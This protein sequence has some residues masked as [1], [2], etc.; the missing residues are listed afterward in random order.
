MTGQLNWISLHTMPE[1][2]YSVSDLSKSFK[3]G[4]TQDMRKLIKIV[5]RVKS[6]KGKVIIDE[7][8]EEGIYWEAYA[9]A[10]FGN[11]E[12]G[13]TQIGYIISLTDGKRRCPIWWKSRKARRVAKST[14]EA[15]ALSVGEAIEGLV[16]FNKLWEEIVG[17]GKLKAI[18]KTDSKTLMT[19]IKSSTGVSS[20]RLKID[21]AAIRE[22]VELGEIEEVMWIRGKQQIADILTKSGVSEENIRDYLE[23]KELEEGEVLWERGGS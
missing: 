9:D 10:S 17:E 1:I 19:A 22:T 7:L 8:E 6:I 4:T 21:M 3:E 5:R 18:V 13:H 20:K 2:A 15:E 23:G 12:D 16:Y 14:I 11:I